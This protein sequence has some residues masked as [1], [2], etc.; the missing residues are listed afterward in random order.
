F[1]SKL[2]K[3]SDELLENVLTYEPPV[4]ENLT[5]EDILAALTKVPQDFREVLLLADVQEFSYKEVA[6][7]L[8]IPLG[9]VMSRLS[10]GRRILRNEVA[11]VAQS[12]GILKTRE[13]GQQQ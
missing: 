8:Q 10:R 11:N 2:V 3:E 5:D 7:T 9:T 12:M 1:S 6:E 13:A 4:P